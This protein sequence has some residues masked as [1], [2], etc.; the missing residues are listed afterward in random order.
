M[1]QKAIFL[2]T[3]DDLIKTTQHGTM[4]G[5]REGLAGAPAPPRKTKETPY[6][7]KKWDKINTFDSLHMHKY[8]NAIQR[9]VICS[10]T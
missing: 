2:L 1:A 10:H 5:T 6:S 8:C 3:S 9:D 4:G 7:P